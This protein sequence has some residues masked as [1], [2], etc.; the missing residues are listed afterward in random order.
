MGRPR[1][2]LFDVNETLLS[3]AP[4]RARM[5]EIFGPEPL[6]GEWFARMLHGS[7]VSNEIDDYRSFADIG[8]ESLVR[9]SK[10]RSVTLSDSEARSVIDLMRTL[11]PHP[12][13]ARAMVRLSKV[14][15]ATATLTN[16]SSSV[17]KEQ[18]A[19][20]GL[21]PYID[22]VISVEEVGKFKP[23]P[24]TYLYAADTCAI[25]ISE[26]VLVAAHDWDCAGALAAGMKTVFL[27]R[28][29]A[30]WG[31]PTKQPPTASDLVELAERLA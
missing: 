5:E 11:P 15:Y 10:T 6:V 12:E 13:V 4:I 25:D 30:V 22:R 1:L 8:V 18:I 16:G 31:L 20:S 28:P 26:V 9:L 2:L 17:A 14:G 19:N 21:K 27:A 7:L 23:H 29:G 24:S 3:L